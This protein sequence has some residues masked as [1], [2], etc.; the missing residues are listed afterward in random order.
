VEHRRGRPEF[1]KVIGLTDRRHGGEFSSLGLVA[2]SSAGD[3]HHPSPLNGTSGASETT[4]IGGFSRI[5]HLRVGTTSATPILLCAF[6][7]VAFGRIADISTRSVDSAR[8]LCR[9]PG[10]LLVAAQRDEGGA[11]AGIIHPDRM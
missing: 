3:L 5:G 8:M 6:G 11:N 1:V 4:G 10:N 2:P 7:E 9:S